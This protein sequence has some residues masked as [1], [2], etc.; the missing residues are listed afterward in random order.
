MENLEKNRVDEITNLFVQLAEHYGEAKKIA[1]RIGQLLCEQRAEMPADDFRDWIEQF[2]A[3]DD[4]SR[5]SC[6]RYMDLWINR[7]R[8][9]EPL[10][11]A[12]AYKQ[13]AVIHTSERAQTESRHE[14]LIN[15]FIAT[16]R[17]SGLWNRT[18]YKRLEERVRANGD[19]AQSHSETMQG[20]EESVR[21]SSERYD[22]A[23]LHATVSFS[24]KVALEE[25]AQKERK[26]IG[27]IIEMLVRFYL[28]KKV[29]EV[30]Y[31]K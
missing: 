24:T 13:L 21:D 17:K 2:T 26:S 23:P 22:L 1:L 3:H 5:S 14:Q 31:G 7:D 16:G 28:E 12:Q 11:L 8:I 19:L 15:E 9:P 27:E 18:T 4:L 25:L 29:K 20:R 30:T 6:Y 10:T